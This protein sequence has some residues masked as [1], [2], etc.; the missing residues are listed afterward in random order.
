MKAARG[1][2]REHGPSKAVVE[3]IGQAGARVVLVGADGALGDVLVATTEAAEA[4][5]AGVDGL[6]PG[7]WDADTVNATRIGAA[8]R[9]RMAGRRLF[10]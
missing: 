8:H 10:S 4:L 1:F 9:N 3:P 7:T 5:I 6:E 2:V